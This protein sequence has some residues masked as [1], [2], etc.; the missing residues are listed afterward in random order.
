MFSFSRSI[1]SVLLNISEFY[2]RFL[3]FCKKY[4][5][6]EYYETFLVF[7][8]TFL[9]FYETFFAPIGHRRKGMEKKI[10]LNVFFL[11]YFEEMSLF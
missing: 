1:F 6:V 11:K 4:L 8:E 7:C 9:V 2:E 10:V 5:V 3:M